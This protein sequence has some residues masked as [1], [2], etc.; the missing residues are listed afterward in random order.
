MLI[1]RHAIAI[2]PI[3]QAKEGH[4]G[5][6]PA[7]LEALDVSH[8]FTVFFGN[9][10]LVPDYGDIRIHRLHLV[11]ELAI[12]MLI[13]IFKQQIFDA[14]NHQVTIL[15]D[16]LKWHNAVNVHS[17]T[18][19]RC[20]RSI[21]RGNRT[22]NQTHHGPLLVAISLVVMLSLLSFRMSLVPPPSMLCMLVVFAM[23]FAYQ[24]ACTSSGRIGHK[25]MF[26]Q[27]LLHRLVPRCHS[28]SLANT[29]AN[30][31]SMQSM[32]GGGTRLIR[33]ERRDSITTKEIATRSGP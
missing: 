31:T 8:C 29:M 18:W 5:H 20:W 28:A 26:P 2:P 19:T 11:P 16:S 3:L 30:T 4:V 10:S 25:P 1:V 23:V 22:R 15:R 7:E 21:M 33:K 6:S 24:K 9:Q 32:L 13:A 27:P 12:T 14:I 17:C